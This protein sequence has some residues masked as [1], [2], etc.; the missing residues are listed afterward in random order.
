MQTTS[1]ADQRRKDRGIAL[2][3]GRMQQ[4]LLRFI[5]AIPRKPIVWRD[6]RHHRVQDPLDSVAA[7]RRRLV[8]A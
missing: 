6:G 7:E 2:L 3:Y 8:R 4:A 1:I 5:G